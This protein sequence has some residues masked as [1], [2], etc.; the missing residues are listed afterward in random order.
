MAKVKKPFYKRWW[1]I[2]LSLFLAIGFIG[3]IFESDESKSERAAEEVALEEKREAVKSAKEDAKKAESEKKVRDEQLAND[4]RDR[5]IAGYEEKTATWPEDTDGV[6]VGTDAKFNE[7]HF[8]IRV[9]VDEATWAASSE[10]EK[11]SFAVTIG[12]VVEQ[13]IDAKDSVWVDIVSATNNDVVAT[14]KM[15]GGWKIKR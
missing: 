13:S 6:I 7:N 2:A 3:V 12:N 5:A 11:E 1:F 9:Y 8:M 14:Q 10:S 4:Q 15:F